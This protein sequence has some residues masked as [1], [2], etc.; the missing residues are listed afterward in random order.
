MF[1]S[2]ILMTA[3]CTSGGPAGPAQS[4]QVS[5]EPT[6]SPAPDCADGTPAT[7]AEVRVGTTALTTH[8]CSRDGETVL[9]SANLAVSQWR[10]TPG[11]DETE[12]AF[13]WVG[14]GGGDHGYMAL[15]F[16]ACP[17]DGCERTTFFSIDSGG[18]VTQLG[19]PTTAHAWGIEGDRLTIKDK[20]GFNPGY[21]IASAT[22]T[23]AWN[24]QAFTP[25]GKPTAKAEYDSWI[26]EDTTV[27][28]VDP[29]TGKPTGQTVTVGQGDAIAVLQ[30][31]EPA[32]T[33]FEYRV[34]G[35]AFWASGWEQN[36]AG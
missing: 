28:I 25:E 32:G 1:W 26:C 6:P 34:K 13:S 15:R 8:S 23:L 2:A 35:T 21:S 20:P 19:K 3:G 16:W 29:Q 36:C 10:W 12:H 9:V 4:E 30:A 27:A 11:D 22:Q 7:S 31:G 18:A 17:M 24:G 5:S 14:Q 33:V